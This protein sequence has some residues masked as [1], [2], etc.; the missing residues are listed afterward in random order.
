M[1]EQH[2]LDTSKY[3]QLTPTQAD[4][5]L[6]KVLNEVHQIVMYEHRD[7]ISDTQLTYFNRGFARQTKV[8]KIYGSPKIHKSDF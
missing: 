7:E 3:M 4:Y 5:I 2:L 6:Q 8:S 1:I